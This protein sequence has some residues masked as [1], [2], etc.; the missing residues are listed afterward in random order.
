MSDKEPPN[1]NPVIASGR[2]CRLKYS[3]DGIFREGR[4]ALEKTAFRAGILFARRCGGIGRARR[5]A[6]V[7]HLLNN[8]DDSDRRQDRGKDRG[9]S[10][11]PSEDPPFTLVCKNSG[12]RNIQSCT[13][14]HKQL[15][16]NTIY[17]DNQNH[18]YLPPVNP[19]GGRKR[20]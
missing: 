9:G 17:K 4:D 20:F 11:M 7:R 16:Y 13:M 15:I 8:A 1:R 14:I 18:P 12:K 6:V 2:K 10:F 3:S 19:L 5:T